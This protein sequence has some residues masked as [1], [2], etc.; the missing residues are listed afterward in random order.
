MRYVYQNSI[1]L[2][3]LSCHSS[4]E[5]HYVKY[6]VQEKTEKE[7]I[8]IH[9]KICTDVGCLDILSLAFDPP[10]S[11]PG[12]YVFQFSYANGSRTCEYH[13]P[14]DDKESCGNDISIKTKKID[15][16]ELRMNPIK[17]IHEM[18]L[19]L[20]PETFDL[21]IT[22]DGKKILHQTYS[23]TY[24]QYRPNGNDCPPTCKSGQQQI[25]ISKTF[26]SNP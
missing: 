16:L 26:K 25:Q 14:T 8:E 10:I 13:L 1:L 5:P 21:N 17:Q 19:L 3:L 2:F 24:S 23:P 15:P 11:Y 20:T 22:R 9:S 4:S 12:N 7:E 6:K 18:V